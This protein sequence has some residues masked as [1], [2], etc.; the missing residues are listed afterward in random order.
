MVDYINFNLILLA[1]LVALLIWLQLPSRSRLTNNLMSM[2]DAA[3][4]GRPIKGTQTRQVRVAKPRSHGQH[5][6][7]LAIDLSNV[8]IPWGWPHYEKNT[9]ETGHPALAN[10]HAHSISELLHFW[11]DRLVQEKHTVDDE[12]YKRR[13]AGWIRTLMEDRY[14]RSSTMAP[15]TNVKWSEAPTNGHDQMDNFSSGRVDK[16][17]AKLL[18]NGQTHKFFHSS[19][20][21]RLNM[22]T[23]LKDLKMP[24]GW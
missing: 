24:W 14:G 17:E 13:K 16:I 3:H 7:E 20:K 5:K 4:E 1:V 12:E 23:Q 9:F 22:H 10:G 6:S 2:A 15:V 21:I 19:G 11:A 18:R 8:P